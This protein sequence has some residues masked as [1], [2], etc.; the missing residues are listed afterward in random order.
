MANDPLPP[1]TTLFAQNPRQLDVLEHSG[2]TADH[3]LQMFD[4][5]VPVLT[6]LDDWERPYSLPPLA[7]SP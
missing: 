6:R 5:G 3:N 7:R 4:A 1:E 2:P